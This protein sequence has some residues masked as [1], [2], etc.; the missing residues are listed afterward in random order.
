MV[1]TCTI[2]RPGAPT[3]DRTTS[4][5]TPGPATTLYSGAC[6]V[7]PQRVPRD[8]H[9]YERLTVTARYEVALPF[10]AQPAQPLHVGDQLTVTASGD[11]R[12]V[13]QVMAVM[14]IDYGSTA[15]AWR[16]T[17]EGIT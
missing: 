14:A 1:D 9:A 4:Q 10:G 3:L 8:K 15:T 2:T 12:L 5:L 7:K 17:V 16:L 11:A 13:G 6:R